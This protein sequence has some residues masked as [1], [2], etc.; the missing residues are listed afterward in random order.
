[1]KCKKSIYLLMLILLM[2]GHSIETCDEILPAEEQWYLSGND[3]YEIDIEAGNMRHIADAKRDKKSVIVAVIDSG[4]DISNKEIASSIWENTEEIPDNGIDDDGNGFIDDINGW[5]FSGNNNNVSEYKDSI[6]E[7]A[8]GTKVTGII[9]ADCRSGTILGI[10]DNE[11]VEIMPI[12]VLG[13]EFNDEG[14]NWGE[15]DDVIKAIQYAETNGA[16]ICN[17]SLNTYKESDE[18][19]GVIKNSDMLFVVSAGNGS[20]K[21]RDIDKYPSYPASYRFKNVI[22]VSN[23]KSNGRI[24]SKSNYGKGSVDIA[25]PGT[26][27]YGIDVETGYSYGSG[28]SYAAPI[29]TGTAAMLYACD[30][31]MTNDKCKQIIIESA[32]R[33]EQLERKVNGGQ[34]LNCKNSIMRVR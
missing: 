23:I 9:C 29:V 10:A 27:I 34:I 4:I 30:K 14:S 1:M 7:I 32:D 21:T 8:H 3:N 31:T 33:K 12:K 5:N 26:D 17:I 20:G 15:I 28:T 11:Y 22:T 18:L 25:A 19:A 13:E 6:Y 24:N 16:S 2:I